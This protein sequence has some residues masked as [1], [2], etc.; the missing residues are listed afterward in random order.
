MEVF[1]YCRSFTWNGNLLKGDVN[2]FQQFQRQTKG[3][4]SN[5]RATKLKHCLH[6]LRIEIHVS[7]SKLTL[8]RLLGYLSDIHCL[9]YVAF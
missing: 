8:P 6:C 9:C 3:E 1:K 2:V 5:V 7:P 4:K